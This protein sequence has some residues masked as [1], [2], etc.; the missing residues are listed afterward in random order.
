[1]HLTKRLMTAFVIIKT[2]YSIDIDSSNIDN[3]Q[4]LV[5]SGSVETIFRVKESVSSNATVQVR[6]RSTT[7]VGEGAGI[8][9]GVQFNILDSSV[10]FND[11]H[12]NN[13]DGGCIVSDNS[14]LLVDNC[15]LES[16]L[17]VEGGAIWTLG[18][19]LAILNSRFTGNN[20]TKKGGAV[21][22]NGTQIS[23]VD[24]TFSENNSGDGGGIYLSDCSGAIDG[25]SYSD[26]NAV[27]DLQDPNVFIE[28]RS[29][30]VDLNSYRI[31]TFHLATGG[32]GVSIYGSVVDVRNS[33][34]VDNYATISGGAMKSDNT[35]IENCTFVN[36][37]AGLGG[38]IFTVNSNI[39]SS[40][41]DG[42]EGIHSGGGML[43]T[44]YAT[45]D[46]MVCVNNFVS[47]KVGRRGFAG[48]GCIRNTG[49]KILFTESTIVS[50]NTAN[51]GGFM[52]VDPS[53]SAKILG[54]S[55][56]DCFARDSGGA[57]FVASE[58]SLEIV[59]GDF[60][61]NSAGLDGGV[62]FIRFEPLPGVHFN[63]SNANFYN[64]SAI[65]AG[66]VYCIIA[67]LF[68]YNSTFVNNSASFNSGVFLMERVG[69]FDVRS[70]TFRGNE[71]GELG[72]V[73]YT[74]LPVDTFIGDSI[75]DG[76][77]ALSGSFL[78]VSKSHGDTRI[79][80]SVVRDNYMAESVIT[81]TSASNVNVTNTIFEGGGC[82]CKAIKLTGTASVSCVDSSFYGWDSSSVIESSS[83]V[84]K[85]V[86]LVEC[87]FYNSD[88]LSIFNSEM[89]SNVAIN[90]HIDTETIRSLQVDGHIETTK[91]CLSLG[92]C[93]G[94]LDGVLGVSCTCYFYGMSEVCHHFGEVKVQ[95]YESTE[96]VFFPD[97]VEFEIELLNVGTSSVTWKLE[98]IGE[99]DN[100][101]VIFPDNGFLKE[102]DSIKSKVVLTPDQGETHDMY[103]LYRYNSSTE[104]SVTYVYYTCRE[105]EI[106]VGNHTCQICDLA[107]DGVMGSYDCSSSGVTVKNLPVSRGYWRH[108]DSSLRIHKCFHEDS[109]KGSTE[110]L[111]SD[112]YCASGHNGPYCAVC[113]DDYGQGTG[114]LCFKC[115]EGIN[116][117]TV[118]VVVGFIVLAIF[119]VLF[120]AF[121]IG[122]LDVI[123][124][125]GTYFMSEETKTKLITKFSRRIPL[126][127]IKILIVVWQILT[128]FPEIVNITY[129]FYY[130]KFV[131]WISFISFDIGKL[132][133]STCMF[134]GLD[135]YDRLLTVTTYPIV[136]L[137]I[138]CVTYHISV[139]INPSDRLD[140][141]GRHI[142]VGLLISFF[143]FTSVS[144]TIFRTFICDDEA[145]PG[146]SFLRSDYTIECYDSRH[147][148]YRV[149]ASIMILVYPIGIPLAYIALLFPYRNIL[150][151][152]G[153]D[154]KSVSRSQ[155]FDDLKVLP[156]KFLWRDFR[157]HMYYYESI[158]C[159]RR[160]LLTGLL[161]FIRPGSSVQTIFAVLLAFICLVGFEVS[162][163]HINPF[164]TWTYRMGTVIVFLTNYMGLLI[165]VQEDFSSG[166]LFDI[167]LISL[168]VGL[169]LLVLS[170]T[171]VSTKQ[172]I[173]ET[174]EI[175]REVDTLADSRSS[176]AGFR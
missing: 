173:T 114:G 63:I 53:S 141:K 1:M 18:G 6:N 11:L 57:I 2:A 137:L 158:E 4:A 97:S 91:N 76:N 170:S 168:N 84:E 49:G 62:L 118:L 125:V 174:D 176:R 29:G 58:S 78:H 86:E 138:L 35:N 98:N 36:N 45:M 61:S 143:I 71:C 60:Y 32:G 111:S 56:H 70:C 163:P 34:F 146:K 7:F 23:I 148:V 50:N 79:Y 132:L 160:I 151:P 92:E 134:P 164:D 41:I 26:N 54:G 51:S 102:N 115:E 109:C 19:E 14:N 67:D 44:G 104:I 16:N 147:T 107:I 169:I 40:I 37:T 140:I 85:S 24:S 101:G 124:R 94:C 30:S 145:I 156:F 154:N 38:G 96:V 8:Q 167:V 88:V 65:N 12:M 87:G 22:S 3:I 66:V 46:D 89:G 133:S 15:V 74:A 106:E 77:N 112:D 117:R 99:H 127:S 10:S 48:G 100:T 121:L 162:R 152:V 75:I 28:P 142:T 108:S 82:E 120:F 175:K 131:R 105:S 157:P 33:V 129:P 17:A 42:N 93:T 103:A 126:Y 150:H 110:I 113:D 165:R 122:G 149:Y 69:V 155:R 128:I 9:L 72:G 83:S 136:L 59:G 161:V 43:V 166:M 39:T 159:I 20:A 25:V 144:T 68:V 172:I 139:R 13:C 123:V 21:F 90:N 135:F 5:D 95:T 52:V 27:A 119:L 171:F 116:I 47:S 130:A 31:G 153:V 55:F 64:N 80:N 81:L 73:I